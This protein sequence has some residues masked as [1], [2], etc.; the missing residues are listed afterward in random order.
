MRIKEA[1]LSLPQF[2]Y[3]PTVIFLL[4][5]IQHR[6]S[7]VIEICPTLGF[8]NA[9]IPVSSSH[10]GRSLDYRVDLDNQTFHVPSPLSRRGADKRVTGCSCELGRVSLR[11]RHLGTT[12]HYDCP[13]RRPKDI[14]EALSVAPR[15]FTV[16]D[17]DNYCQ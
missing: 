17:D 11:A 16:P 14:S 13:G 2:S 3:P 8:P 6:Q 9:F 5:R 7:L 12:Y 4:L 1:N 10:P 15:P